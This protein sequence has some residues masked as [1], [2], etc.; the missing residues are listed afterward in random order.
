[1]EETCD[2]CGFGLTS[3]AC[4]KADDPKVVYCP[5]C[6]EKN[7][8]RI[9]TVMVNKSPSSV[10]YFKCG[11]GHISMKKVEEVAEKP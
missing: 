2:K 9:T 8:T 7:K 10:G 11:Y 6:Y 4:A 5:V 3:C 1:M